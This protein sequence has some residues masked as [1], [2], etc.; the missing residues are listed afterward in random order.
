[1]ERLQNLG[2]WKLSDYVSRGEFLD[3][4]VIELEARAKDGRRFIKT[5]LVNP[6][7]DA[8]THTRRVVEELDRILGCSSIHL[9]F[10]F[11]TGLF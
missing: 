2:I 5:E 4:R 8:P 1:M 10:S 6:D 11:T 9:R 3:G 7:G